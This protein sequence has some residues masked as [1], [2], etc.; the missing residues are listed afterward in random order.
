MTPLLLALL[1]QVPADGH[2]GL[3]LSAYET[4]ASLDGE[5]RPLLGTDL[6]GDGCDDVLLIREESTEIFLALGSVEGLLDARPF[7][8]LVQQRPGL[9]RDVDEDGLMEFL[10]F[11]DSIAGSWEVTEQGI[12]RWVRLGGVGKV[13]HRASFW[14]V[15]DFAHRSESTLRSIAHAHVTGGLMSWSGIWWSEGPRASWTEV[16][17]GGECITWLAGYR[18]RAAGAQGIT[19]WF[20]HDRRESLRFPVDVDGDGVLEW[21]ATVPVE[22]PWS[23]R[24]APVLLRA[25]PPVESVD[26]SVRSPEVD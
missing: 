21:M 14:D 20:F 22:N 24:R 19:D 15:D 9:F 13:L 5:L 7:A 10:V 26:G 8:E 11:G 4:V 17:D 23:F 3:R 1:P 16:W 6:D 2:V 12:G 18:V 25:R